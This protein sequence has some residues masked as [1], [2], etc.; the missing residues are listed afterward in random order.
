MSSRDENLAAAQLNGG[1]GSGYGNQI[2]PEAMMKH[3]GK[4]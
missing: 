1:F 4:F 3:A 2:D